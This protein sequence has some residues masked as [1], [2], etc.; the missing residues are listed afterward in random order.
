[1]AA[2]GEGE[3]RAERRARAAGERGGRRV[4]G[5]RWRARTVHRLGGDH[6]RGDEQPVH[7]VHR[8][9]ER[10]VE[11]A[12]ALEVPDGDVEADEVELG[13]PPQAHEVAVHRHRR[14]RHG[15]EDGRRVGAHVSVQSTQPLERIRH[16]P[17]CHLVI[18]V[19][20]SGRLLAARRGNRHRKGGQLGRCGQARA[21]GPGV[22]GLI[23]DLHP[24]A[25][26]PLAQR[27]RLE[28]RRGARVRAGDQSRAVLC[29]GLRGRRLAWGPSLA[30]PYC[31]RRGAR[32]QW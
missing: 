32:E 29:A 19:L 11:A 18:E 23:G 3:R 14:R 13:V 28:G 10:D 6:Q 26:A 9:A 30:G 27:R 12:E 2:R 17:Q 21:R 16:H 22:I 7:V 25:P 15:V 5:L 1:M 20:G 24:A 8:G 31:T 4:A